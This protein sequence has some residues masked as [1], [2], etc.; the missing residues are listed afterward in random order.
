M[1]VPK[2]SYLFIPKFDDR[3][4]GQTNIIQPLQRFVYAPHSGRSMQIRKDP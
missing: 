1:F 3:S 2:K 4:S